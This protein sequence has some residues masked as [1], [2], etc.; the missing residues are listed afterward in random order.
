MTEEGTSIIC[1]IRFNVPS[2]KGTVPNATLKFTKAN[3]LQTVPLRVTIPGT[4]KTVTISWVSLY[5]TLFSTRYK[6]IKKI[7]TVSIV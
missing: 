7:V 3:L 5:P 1:V 4:A 2:V 6:I